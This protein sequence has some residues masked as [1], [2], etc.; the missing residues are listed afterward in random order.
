MRCALCTLPSSPTTALCCRGRWRPTGSRRG[1]AVSAALHN[2]TDL[3]S[4]PATPWLMCAQGRRTEVTLWRKEGGKE[5]LRGTRKE[6]LRGTIKELFLLTMVFS[7]VV[8][9][10]VSTFKSQ[11]HPWAFQRIIVLITLCGDSTS[12]CSR[13]ESSV[14]HPPLLRWDPRHVLTSIRW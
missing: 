10:Y 8:L 6:L 14:Y 9:N 13:D 3:C 4:A 2:C 7:Y 11:L 5:L 12:T 1:G